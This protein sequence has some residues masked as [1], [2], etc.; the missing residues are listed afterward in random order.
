LALLGQKTW[1]D[2]EI[3]NCR[4]VKNAQNIDLVDT[5]FEELVSDKS[6]IETCNFLRSHADIL[7]QQYKENVARQIY[8][9]SQLCNRAKKDKFK[10]VLALMN[11]IQIHDSCSWNEESTAVP[12]TKTVIGQR[13]I[14]S[15]R[16]LQ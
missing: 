14:K 7:D 11:E 9:T 13:R 3:K 16:S 8:N 5:V 15:K 4:F 2:D 6:F 10:K 1:N 12:L